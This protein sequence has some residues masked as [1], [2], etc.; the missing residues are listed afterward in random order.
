LRI[1]PLKNTIRI[2]PTLQQTLILC[3][4]SLKPNRKLFTPLKMAKTSAKNVRNALRR[5]GVDENVGKDTS[6]F[7]S[8]IN[9]YQISLVEIQSILDKQPGY[10]NFE[11]LSYN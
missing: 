5:L 2:D 9:N 10:N 8:P 4:K 7:G 1:V 6:V 11:L 3:F